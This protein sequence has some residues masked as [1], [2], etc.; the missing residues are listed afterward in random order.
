MLGL[1]AIAILSLLF[2]VTSCVFSMNIDASEVENV[3][4]SS[5]DQARQTVDVVFNA[6][7]KAESAGADVFLLLDR[8]D[9]AAG[10][11]ALADICLRIGDFDGAVGNAS[12]C[13]K[14][15]EGIVEDAEALTERAVVESGERY[16]IGVGSSAVG[17]V[18]VACVSFLSWRLFKRR[19][20]R[21]VLEMKPEVV[22]VEP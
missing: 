2:T 12:L 7:L 11:L 21:R 4:I 9:V 14:A 5:V 17:M 16:W 13:V 20:Y 6:V 15:S 1:K 8:L 18:V 19:Y 10:H 22:D 3:A